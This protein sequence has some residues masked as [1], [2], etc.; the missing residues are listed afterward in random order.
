MKPVSPL[1][2]IEY[3]PKDS[4]I[5][6]G[7]QYNGQIGNYYIYQQQHCSADVCCVVCIYKVVYYMVLYTLF[8]ISILGH[9][10]GLTARRHDAY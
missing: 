10:E 3:N 6:V 9:K 7:G 8:V 2:C 5:L 1:V 4:H